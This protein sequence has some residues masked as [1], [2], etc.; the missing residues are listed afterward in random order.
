MVPKHILE[1]YNENMKRLM[2]L[3]EES[4]ELTN[5]KTYLEWIA[6]LPYGVHSEDNLD[7]KNVKDLLDSEH[8]GLEEVKDRILEFVA[9]G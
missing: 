3:G 9:V 1:V 6:S 5:V 7:I 2:S 4:S 8:Y